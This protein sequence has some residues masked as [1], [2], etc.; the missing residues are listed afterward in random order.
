[1]TLASSSVPML[2]NPKWLPSML[3]AMLSVISKPSATQQGATLNS[4]V[5]VYLSFIRLFLGLK[6]D[7]SEIWCGNEAYA[8]PPII[9]GIDVYPERAGGDVEFA[10]PIGIVSHLVTLPGLAI[11]VLAVLAGVHRESLQALQARLDR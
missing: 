2:A 4:T 7:A 6:Q 9:R 3:I 11:P 1:M 10:V 8:Q 5:Q